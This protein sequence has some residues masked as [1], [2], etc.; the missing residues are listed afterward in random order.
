MI[1]LTPIVGGAESLLMAG[2]LAA[3][4]FVVPLLNKY[5][6][7]HIDAKLQASLQDTLQQAAE[8]AGG[9]VYETIRSHA[10]TIGEANSKNIGLDL[11]V[12][13]MVAH[14]P[15]AMESAGW[16]PDMI[17]NKI[18]AELGKLTAADPATPMIAAPA[19]APPQLALPAP[20]APAA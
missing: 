16:T 14:V 18:T 11:A 7:V 19:A 17:R 9:L 8:S 6:H 20:A 3:I 2:I 10:A 13:Y 15:D 1:D 5:L 4:P 12:K